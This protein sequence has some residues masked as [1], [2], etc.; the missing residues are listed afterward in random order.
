MNY[1]KDDLTFTVPLTL[2]AHQIA[3]QFYEHQSHSK[4]AK[5]IYLNT[6][7]VYAV[8]FYL[9]CLGIETDLDASDSWNP[10]MQFLANTADLVIKNQ[11]KLEC[12]FLL[13]QEEICDIP[14]E[15]MSDRIGYVVVQL[16]QD[17]TE[18]T[19]LGFTPKIVTEKL[20]LSQLQS[21][22][23]LL[24]HLNSYKLR[25]FVQIQ[26]LVQLNQWL[27]HA[28]AT[29]WEA[30]EELFK[31]PQAELAFNFRDSYSIKYKQKKNVA[32]GVKRGKLFRFKQDGE[33]MALII[34]V[35]PTASLELDISV[36]VYPTNGQT[37][38]PPDLHL[39]VLDE[40]GEAVMQAKARSTESIQLEF[41][42]EP[43]ESFG[44]KVALGDVSITEEFLI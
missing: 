3:Q 37:Y 26:E 27:H 30:V 18:A 43:G 36:E 17:L 39:M 15:V 11:G 8:N 32:E 13:P 20:P 23:E 9:E 40:A 35:K 34:G 1:P 22:E 4:K 33:P 31:P 28:F 6:L 44:V 38:L 2:A 16:N 24:G 41:S 12:R 14:S 7:A 21:L 10:A 5:Q 19:L 29:G 42:G 25:Q